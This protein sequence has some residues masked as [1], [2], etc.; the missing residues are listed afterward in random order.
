MDADGWTLVG[1]VDVAVLPRR[2]ADERAVRQLL[3]EHGYG[4][5][6]DRDIRWELSCSRDDDD[7]PRSTLVVYVAATPSPPRVRRKPRHA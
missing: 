7:A 2:Q 4:G 5:T 6:Q 3:E 1:S